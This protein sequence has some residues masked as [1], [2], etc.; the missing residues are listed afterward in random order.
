MI[1]QTSSSSRPKIVTKSKDG[2]TVRQAG[3]KYRSKMHIMGEILTAASEHSGGLTKTK[4][5]YKSFL[6]YA[7][8]KDYLS[9]MLVDSL[10][11]YN[12]D[13]KRFTVTPKGFKYLENYRRMSELVP[14]VDL[15]DNSARRGFHF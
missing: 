10:L 5:M 7:Q 11:D 14:N 4:I 6:S 15:C 1:N 3:I 12:E 13:S 2:R 8:T 9:N